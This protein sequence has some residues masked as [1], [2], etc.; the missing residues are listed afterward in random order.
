MPKYARIENLLIK[1]VGDYENIPGP[2]WKEITEDEYGIY[3]EPGWAWSEE[4]QVF[5]TPSPH[6]S[7]TFNPSTLNWDAPIMRPQ[8]SWPLWPQWN[9]G[10]QRWDIQNQQQ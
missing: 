9:E 6:P 2:T 8:V 5:V 7:W 1:E 10:E 3:P 4:Y